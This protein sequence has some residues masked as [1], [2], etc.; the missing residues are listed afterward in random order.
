M[1]PP[2]SIMSLFGLESTDVQVLAILIGAIAIPMVPISAFL[3]KVAR[4]IDVIEQ[5]LKNHGIIITDHS[6]DAQEDKE[7][8]NQCMINI[9]VMK[10]RIEYLE[11]RKPTRDAMSEWKF[12]RPE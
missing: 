12:E 9:E 7:R 1:G 5:I 6:K 4:S 11:A 3:I 10:S 2:N 8:L